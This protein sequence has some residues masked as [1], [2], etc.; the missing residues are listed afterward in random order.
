M[1]N[2]NM[3]RNN[4]D[5]INNPD[6]SKYHWITAREIDNISLNSAGQVIDT[7][8]D[9]R[10]VTAIQL[11]VTF[12]G[13]AGTVL[14]DI[15]NKLG[16]IEVHIGGDQG[17]GAKFSISNLIDL[18]YYSMYASKQ[19]IQQG[20]RI[21]G[22]GNISTYM[23][24]IPLSPNPLFPKFGFKG[25]R[26]VIRTNDNPASGNATSFTLRVGFLVHDDD[27]QYYINTH[28]ISGTGGTGGKFFDFALMP[29]SLLMGALGYG[30]TSY[31]D[32]LF[33]IDAVTIR[34]FAVVVGTSEEYL[35]RSAYLMANIPIGILTQ[36]TSV[37]ILSTHYLW[38]DL[39]WHTG[40]GLLTNEE[41]KFRIRSGAADT[42]RLHIFEAV[43][44]RTNT[45]Q[46]FE[47][48]QNNLRESNAEMGRM[49]AYTRNR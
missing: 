15:H 32:L 1:Y 34:D 4:E 17:G 2:Q 41:W 6:V 35:A 16:V 49:R 18:P 25:G 29:G 36:G 13:N 31:S 9:V 37:T 10:N 28:T 42:Y 43:K 7:Y 30:T 27:P 40:T 44:Y 5:A 23:Y 22:A 19:Y 39:G 11:M 24:T 46:D 8:M 26:L 47:T 48:M 20:L 38:W 45:P 14:E 3:L 33:T 21:Q 12:N